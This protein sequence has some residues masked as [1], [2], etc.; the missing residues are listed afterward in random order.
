MFPLD[1]AALAALKARH[2]AF[3]EA[4]VVS[5][6]AEAEWRANLEAVHR[7]LLA[8][9]LRDL[10][11]ASALA[12]A[13]NTLLTSEAVERVVRPIAKRAIAELFTELRAEKGKFSDRIS[14]A[15][16]QRIDALL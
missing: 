13:A 15:A 11:R 8:T 1:P 6:K 16:R 2:I 3:F 10:V 9:R 4:R 14:P 12:D 7:D 5:P